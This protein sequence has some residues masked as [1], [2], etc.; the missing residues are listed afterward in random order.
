MLSREA[1]EAQ[2][3]EL[4][5]QSSTAVRDV[6][7]QRFVGKESRMLVVGFW[8]GSILSRQDSQQA[9]TATLFF[10]GV[11]QK[12]LF[13]GWHFQWL[14][15]VKNAMDWISMWATRVHFL[16]RTPQRGR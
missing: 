3:P 1:K 16:E 7:K 2:K 6:M 8:A 13:R 14:R 4:S 5:K 12:R 11:I 9:K 10:V 15:T